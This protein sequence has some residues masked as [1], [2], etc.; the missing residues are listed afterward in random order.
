MYV[1]EHLK[2]LDRS[3]GRRYGLV[4]GSATSVCAWLGV[5]G[6]MHLFQTNAAVVFEII[7][8]FKAR[9]IYK[10]TTMMILWE[11]QPSTTRMMIIKK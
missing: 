3:T 6:G 1:L 2:E 4:P 7:L 10:S 8:H 5:C 9:L 11:E